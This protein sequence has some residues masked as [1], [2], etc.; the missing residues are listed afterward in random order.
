MISNEWFFR[1]FVNKKIK[2]F[3]RFEKNFEVLKLIE[4]FQITEMFL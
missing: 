3:G 2:K 4:I 1:I